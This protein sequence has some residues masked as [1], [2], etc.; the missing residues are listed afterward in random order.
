MNADINKMAI[1]F[2]ANKLAV[3][4]NKTKYIIFRAK[5]KKLNANMPPLL[6]MKMNLTNN[7]TK[8]TLQY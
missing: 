1:W 2:K 3:N 6:L 8:T 4:K 5:G 7:L